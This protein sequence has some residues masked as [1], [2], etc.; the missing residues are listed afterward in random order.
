MLE[1]DRPDAMVP[2]ACD[3][4]IRLLANI[5]REPGNIKF[6]WDSQ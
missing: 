3:I 1:V 5:V 2:E 6:R 4:L